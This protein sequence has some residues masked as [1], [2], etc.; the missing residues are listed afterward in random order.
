MG[1]KTRTDARG[2]FLALGAPVSVCYDRWRGSR[3]AFVTF[4]CFQGHNY[5]IG[6]RSSA[7]LKPRHAA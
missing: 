7:V 4:V 1:E 2:V 6:H 5:E 3:Q